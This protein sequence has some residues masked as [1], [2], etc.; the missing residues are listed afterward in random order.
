MSARVEGPDRVSPSLDEEGRL[1]H[2]AF[3]GRPLEEQTTGYMLSMLEENLSVA[4]A[5]TAALRDRVTQIEADARRA[6]AYW[7]RAKAVMN[8]DLPTYGKLLFVILLVQGGDVRMTT[9]K[10]AGLMSSSPSTVK[11]YRD[12]LIERRLIAWENAGM[13]GRH[14]WTILAEEGP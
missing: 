4:S 6:D 13:G 12:M 2:G 14:R 5:E 3:A 11:R 9:E 1:R 8:S 10:V 7:P